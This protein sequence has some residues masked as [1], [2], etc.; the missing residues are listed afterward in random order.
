M[1]G[2]GEVARAFSNVIGPS[3]ESVGV[4]G[5]KA[6]GY[7]KA[8]DGGAYETVAVGDGGPDGWWGFVTVW[9]CT[10]DVGWMGGRGVVP[11]DAGPHC[12]FGIH[13][14]FG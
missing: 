8:E 5:V 11:L 2:M 12:R 1:C 7:S 3:T 6:V 14:R 10:G 13:F 4:V 9:G